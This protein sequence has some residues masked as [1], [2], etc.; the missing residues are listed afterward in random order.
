MKTQNMRRQ[1]DSGCSNGKEEEEEE[2]D[3][4]SIGARGETHERWG[5]K[6]GEVDMTR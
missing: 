2:E 4:E 6:E 5:D 1:T 3:G